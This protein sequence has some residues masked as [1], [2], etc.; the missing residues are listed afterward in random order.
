MAE[1]P[2]FM[3]YFDAAPAFERLDDADAGRL[4]KAMLAYSSTGELLP[5]E[6]MASLAFDLIRPKLDRDADKYVEKIQ[7]R[8]Y[9]GYS[10]ACRDRGVEPLDLDSWLE[11]QNE[12]VLAN[13]CTCMPTVTTTT[14][15]TS[16]TAATTAP[17]TTTAT[18]AASKTDTDTTVNSR[19][20]GKG[21]VRENP[22]DAAEFE[23]LR[24]AK[25]EMVR[26]YTGE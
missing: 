22:G 5:L 25:L 17:T 13:A 24:R 10:K 11:G 19:G 8:K 23:A 6:G 20:S 15:T 14:A 1:R 12:H 16:N 7:K 2:G 21:S 3:I 4:I 18:A 26:N 9:A